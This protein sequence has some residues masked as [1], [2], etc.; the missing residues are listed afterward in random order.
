MPAY[1]VGMV[2]ARLAVDQSQQGKALAQCFRR[3]TAKGVAAGS[4][5]AA[6]LIVV[7][8]VDDNAAASTS[9]TVS[10]E[11]R[12]SAATLRTYEGRLTA[13]IRPLTV[14]PRPCHRVW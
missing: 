2:F 13:L 6:R 11:T 5:A 14:Q 1:P 10:S 12:T 4:V 9:D 3:G 7:D 8:A